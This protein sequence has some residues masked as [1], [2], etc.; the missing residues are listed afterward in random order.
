MSHL[1]LVTD[2][3]GKNGS[4]ALARVT[5]GKSGVEIVEVVPLAGGAF[6]AQLVPQIAGLLEKH[7]YRKSDLAAFAVVSGPGSFAGLRVCL[8]A[9]QPLAE[10]LQKPI[11]AIA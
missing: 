9:I 6:P 11:A 5:P 8:R 1:L 4:V 7:G 3:S 10:T 2:T